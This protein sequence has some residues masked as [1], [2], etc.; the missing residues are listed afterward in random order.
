MRH[1]SPAK[2][3]RRL[4]LKGVFAAPIGLPMMTAR[5]AQLPAIVADARQLSFR[6]THTDERLEVVYHDGR[7]YLS[8]ALQRMNWLLRDF[9]TGEAQA[10]D[11]QLFDILHALRI[12]LGGGTFEIISA[13]RS[14]GTNEMLRKTGGGGVAK[15]SLHMD[16]RAIDIRIPGVPTHRLR[17]AAIDLGLGGVGYYP[18][19]DFVHVDTGA[20]RTW[21]PNSA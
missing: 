11:P 1:S 12:N 17:D 7:N 9:R 3:L 14:P 15:R 4:L 6:H 18:E 19:S 21:G 10:M 2:N 8:P 20:V 16:G 5:A 13:Y